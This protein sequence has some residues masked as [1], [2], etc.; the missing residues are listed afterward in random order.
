MS[1]LLFGYK[2]ENACPACS[3][4]ALYIAWLVWMHGKAYRISKNRINKALSGSNA[5]QKTINKPNFCYRAL[6][7]P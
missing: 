6:L 4:E 3:A 5:M 1:G 7:S 2:L